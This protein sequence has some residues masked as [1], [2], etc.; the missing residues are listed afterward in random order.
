[1]NDRDHPLVS[2]ITPVYNDADRLVTC[3]RS[4]EEQT[5]P[6]GQYEVI[7][8][9]NASEE[10]VAPVVAPFDHARDVYEARPGSYA[11]RN[12]GI[13]CARGEVVAF[14]DADCI[15]HHAWLEKGVEQ[16]I[17]NASCGLVGGR[18]D[19][20]FS[21]PGKPSP[22]ELFDS[23]HFL[24]QKQYVEQGNFAATANAFTWKH[25]FDEVGLFDDTLRSGGDTEW[26]QRVAAYGYNVCYA[27]NARV[28]HPTRRS[29][30]DLRRKKLRIV[31]GTV[32]AKMARGYPLHEVIADM[33]RDIGHHVKYA[34]QT[35]LAE[36]QYGWKERATLLAAFPIQ[37]ACTASKRL[38]LW[39]IS[40][41][42]VKTLQ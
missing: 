42:P 24:K 31:E 33:T 18:V 9:D 38:W 17:Q 11:A 13:E 35:L 8:V 37:G 12:R 16:L 3:L 1:M 4:L 26:G 39:G 41:L 6:R 30:R 25:I 32:D 5:Y 28:Q 34:V 2:V 22:A 27:E 20:F 14:T 7:V 40:R 10:S 29:Y 36:K 23:T 15:P 21:I 19:F